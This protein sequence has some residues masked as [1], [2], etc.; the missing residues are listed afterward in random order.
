M[1]ILLLPILLDDQLI[2][3]Y[4][5]TEDLKEILKVSQRFLKDK[6]FLK[7]FSKIKGFSKKSFLKDFSKV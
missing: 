6:R 2:A 1:I 7:D 5:V 3:D 4:G